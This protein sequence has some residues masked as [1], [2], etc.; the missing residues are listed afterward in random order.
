MNKLECLIVCYAM[1]YTMVM[2][3]VGSVQ[4]YKCLT[5]CRCVICFTDALLGTVIDKRDEIT[6][7]AYQFY[8]NAKDV[9]H[10]VEKDSGTTHFLNFTSEGCCLTDSYVEDI[11]IRF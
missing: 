9:E 8:R 3:S 5:V 7:L 2:A 10:L 6:Q 4:C 11:W 1:C